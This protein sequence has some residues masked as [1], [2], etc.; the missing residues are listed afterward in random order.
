MASCL[1]SLCIQTPSLV[2][3]APE[4]SDISADGR[5]VA[6]RTYQTVWMYQTP[7]DGSAGWFNVTPCEAPV[8][9]EPQ[10]EAVAIRQDS[11]TL[12]LV[13][14]SEGRNEPLHRI[15]QQQS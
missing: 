10:G 6:L 15:G 14:V 13:T 5:T 7:P 12:E 4:A 8:I 11:E 9:T 2:Q 1:E 3:T